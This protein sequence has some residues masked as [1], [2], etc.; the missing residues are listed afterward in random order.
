MKKTYLKLQ[1]MIKNLYSKEKTTAKQ[2]GI[3]W[4][5]S[6]NNE[7]RVERNQLLAGT[8]HLS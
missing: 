5:R 6:T 2:L 4:V 8:M 7:A 1:L 3:R